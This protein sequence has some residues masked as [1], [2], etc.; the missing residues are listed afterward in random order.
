MWD[1]SVVACFK[2]VSQHLPRGTDENHENLVRIAS[3]SAE[4]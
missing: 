4:K 2:V 3:L 1:K